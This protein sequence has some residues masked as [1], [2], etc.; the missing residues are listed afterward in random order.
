MTQEE[1]EQIRLLWNARSD[2]D[3][4][5]YVYLY[6]DPLNNTVFYI[7]KGKD[8]RVFDHLADRSE[9]EKTKRI[10]AIRNQGQEPDI[11]ILAD[12]LDEETSFRI[13]SAVIDVIGKDNLTNIQYGHNTQRC[14]ISNSWRVREEAIIKH[15]VIVII[16]NKYFPKYF[17]NGI[18]NSSKAEDIEKLF[19]ITRMMWKLNHNKIKDV[20]YIFSSYRGT[21]LDVFEID[22]SRFNGVMNVG[23]ADDLSMFN[24]ASDGKYYFEDDKYR[25]MDAKDIEG[26]RKNRSI[27]FGKIAKD[28]IRI[29]YKN[30]FLKTESKGNPIKYLHG[31]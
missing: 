31:E 21:I 1:L 2:N 23:T 20:Q 30:K 3:N 14:P 24:L 5:W 10:E 18:Y 29:L 9:K 19:A 4:R 28:E 8:N 12:N 22:H 26:T 11:D 17:R 7:G 27:L 15:N 16:I 13:E 25:S 6:I